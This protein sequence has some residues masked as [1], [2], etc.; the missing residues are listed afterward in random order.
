MKKL[1]V[2]LFLI[3][4][5]YS[6]AQITVQNKRELKQENYILIFNSQTYE[7]HWETSVAKMIQSKIEAADSNIF[8]RIVHAGIGIHKSFVSE[9]SRMSGT[10]S[11]GR[12]NSSIVIPSQ[13]IFIGEEGWMYYKIMNLKGLWD[14][15]PVVICNSNPMILKDFRTFFQ[16][17][18]FDDSLMVYVGE[19]NISIP[20]TGVLNN[21]S[22]ASEKTIELIQNLMPDVNL[23]TFVSENNYADKRC[24][25]NLRKL[26]DQNFPN[27]QLNVL[28]IDNNE[29]VIDKKLQE[30]PPNSAVIVNSYYPKNCNVPVFSFNDHAPKDNFTVGGYFCSRNTFAQETADKTIKIRQGTR[31]KYIPFAFA[32]GAK[33]YLNQSALNHFKLNRNVNKIENVEFVNIPP[34]F[35][36]RHIYIIAIVIIFIVIVIIS[37]IIYF[38]SKNSRKKLIFYFEKYKQLFNEFQI[39]NDNIPIGLIEFDK[40]G[41]LIS[42][43][44]ESELFF[45]LLPESDKTSNFNLFNISVFD[46]NLR[47]NIN[48]HNELSTYILL[49]DHFLRIIFK[50]FGG[51]N[52]EDK[53]TILAL[54][55]DNT[56]FEHEKKGKDLMS[57]IFHFATKASSIGVAEY[58]YITKNGYS[59]E[60]WYT[61]FGTPQDC[62]LDE[63]F[64]T[65]AN[66]YKLKINKFMAEAAKNKAKRF[67]ENIFVLQNGQQHWLRCIIQLKEY[68]PEKGI[69]QLV[70]LCMNIDEQIEREHNLLLL[71]RKAKES[72]RLKNEFIANSKDEIK[73][74]LHA[75]VD[76]SIKVIYSQDYNEKKRLNIVIKQNSDILLALVQKAIM[77]AKLKSK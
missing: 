46:K 15:V 39:V 28:T 16:N 68:A 50:K 1:I 8:T 64:E 70:G 73:L 74:P 5:T 32:V 67:D 69:I 52:A 35:F 29:N 34:H 45:K 53:T 7:S 66:P 3:C 59:T 72:E 40:D 42:K 24:L 47:K 23:L 33:N 17:G 76:L 21:F 26:F 30:L 75:I 12:I 38:N 55:I 65:V 11:R 77:E 20:A 4:Q 60:A 14:S 71:M 13:L 62:P 58:N 27:I 48:E 9:R 56:D 10:F 57:D 22:E 31:P 49:G 43:N 6:F 37:V 18:S 63:I 41:Y 2:F 61:N 44:P 51:K 36:I 25:Y 19:S 54:I